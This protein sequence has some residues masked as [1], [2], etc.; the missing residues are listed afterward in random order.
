MNA[1]SSNN[2]SSWSAGRSFAIALLLL[3]AAAASACLMQPPG[4]DHYYHNFET[5]A[6]KAPSQGYTMYWLGKRFQLGEVT[7]SG[8]TVP[9]FGGEYDDGGATIAY[10]ISDSGEST[11]DDFLILLYSPSA[12]KL[13][14]A[15]YET[16]NPRARDTT[17]ED[18]T[19][20]GK[21]AR[22]FVTKWLT[23]ARR[24]DIR[25]IAVEQQRG[26]TA[27]VVSATDG[28]DPTPGAEQA[29]PLM[30]E[31]TFLSVVQHLRPY[32]Q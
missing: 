15:A 12:W 28:I 11:G 29:N 26:D 6:A 21:P 2:T 13:E 18:I 10:A 8:P 3:A 31:Q 30:D 1:V 23:G 16:P 4:P 19:V 22:L 24:G 25:S 5:A 32:P 17:F 27:V 14:A 7:Y 20:A 9:D